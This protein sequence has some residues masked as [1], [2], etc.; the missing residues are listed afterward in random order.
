MN[1][2]NVINACLIFLVFTLSYFL[3]EY[4]H[5]YILTKLGCYKGLKLHWWGVQV[6][7]NTDA[8]V[9]IGFS[10]ILSIYLS[11]FAF[12]FIAYPIFIL[13]GYPSNAFINA[14]I[15]CSLFDFISLAIVLLKYLKLKRVKNLG[16]F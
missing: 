10:D 13:L 9:K 11:G 4:G 16:S 1:S 7:I 12:S 2:L 3:H 8:K 15:C 6:L 5:I 14:Q